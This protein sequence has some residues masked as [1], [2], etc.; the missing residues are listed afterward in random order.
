LTYCQI[1][2][3]YELAVKRKVDD[4]NFQ[5]KLHGGD[6]LEGDDLSPEVAKQKVKSNLLFGDPADYEKLDEG[7]RQQLSEQMMKKFKGLRLGG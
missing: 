7:E 6:P 5:I 4:L 1:I 2:F 3:L